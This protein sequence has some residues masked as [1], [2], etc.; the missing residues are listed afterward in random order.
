MAG[1]D[2]LERNGVAGR[3]LTP[4]Q[5]V[6]YKARMLS[7]GHRNALLGLEHLL[8]ATV[9]EVLDA[10]ERLGGWRP[11]AEQD[12]GSYADVG[13]LVS[14]L[15]RAGE[16]L[17]RACE[18]GER[19]LIGTGHPTGPLQLYVRLSDALRARGAEVLEVAEGSLFLVRGRAHTHSV[20]YVCG[21]ACLTEGSSLLHTHAPDAMEHIMDAG[22]QPDLVVGDHGFAGVAL[23]RGVEAIAMTDTNDPALILAWARGL[24][25]VP[26]LCDDNRPPRSYDP[27]LEILLEALA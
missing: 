7:S 6:V 11:D 26:L 1:L 15:E 8:P 3:I 12:G 27:M 18:R 22:A 14:W 25:V 2:S 20:R 21:V 23:A 19:V 13:A 10:L 9:D 24:P 5:D 17:R 16:R 4:S